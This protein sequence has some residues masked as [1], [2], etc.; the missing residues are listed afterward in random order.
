MVAVVADCPQIPLAG[1]VVSIRLRRLLQGPRHG[2]VDRMAQRPLVVCSS[3]WLT[4][5]TKSGI[6]KVRTHRG[7]GKSYTNR[8]E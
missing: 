6:D 1:R 7:N 3:L 2:D 8:V 5:S 4:A